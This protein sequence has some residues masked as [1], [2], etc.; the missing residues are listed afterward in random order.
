MEVYM[1][2]KQVS[3]KNYRQFDEATI[4][5]ENDI[6]V[7]AGANNSGKTSLIELLKNLLG[8]KSYNYGIND[9]PIKNSK[10]WIDKHYE[11]IKKILNNSD[12]KEIKIQ[13]IFDYMNNDN[14]M[15]VL[16][17]LFHIDYDDTDPIGNFSDYLME[18]NVDEKSFFFS[19]KIL[20]KENLFIDTFDKNYEQIVRRLKKVNSEAT[21]DNTNRL[22]EK[23]IDIYVKSL[24]PE[25]YFCNKTYSNQN[26]MTSAEFK[27][28]FNYKHVIATRELDD[29]STDTKKT[30]SSKLIKYVK[31][32]PA[33]KKEVE[34]IPDEIIS[35]IDNSKIINE[36]RTISDSLLNEPIKEIA[37]TNGGFEEKLLL[38]MD[39]TEGS[40]NTLIGNILEAKYIIGKYYLSENSQGLGYSNLVY[41]HMEIGEFINTVDINLVNILIIEEPEAHLHPQMQR[42]FINY[43]F[44]LYKKE[45]IQGVISTHSDNIVQNTP[46]E[47]TRI[48]RKT[49]FFSSKL[50]DLE[51]FITEIQFKEINQI[52]LA[53]FYQLLF[54]LNLSDIIFADK[55]IMYEGDTERMYIQALLEKEE[56]KLLRD[57]YISYIQ[58]GGAYAHMYAQLLEF[59]NIK[60]LVITDIDYPKILVEPDEILKSEITNSCIKYFYKKDKNTKS[61]E[62]IKVK[63]IYEWKDKII[64]ESKTEK[65]S[66]NILVV[67]QGKKDYYARTLEEAMISKL[68]KNESNVEFTKGEWKLKKKEKGLKFSIPNISEIEKNQ[69]LTND[70]YKISTRRIVDST[71]NSKTDFMYSVILNNLTKEM[72]PN[73]IEEGLV[74]LMK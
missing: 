16:S 29:E 11:T 36:V 22:K 42:V 24:E 27:S 41:L 15:K 28:L 70:T 17:V 66:K 26:K 34:E 23:I 13:K 43:L 2:L 44:S 52:E 47:K 38:D 54:N 14:Y 3:I 33:W 4:N 9:I 45:K 5:F 51:K 30:I 69:G 67:F 71:S 10:D 40:V 58:V 55:V 31:D 72:L 65:F 19:Y 61:T 1:R 59:I 25:F 68:Y 53:T 7:L 21:Y 49:D 57:K 46:I 6:T 18:L 37:K 64:E 56:Y 74:W 62:A 20:L 32:K 60:T 35:I 73:Y 8:N 50:Y 63:K 12:S 39:V 48:L